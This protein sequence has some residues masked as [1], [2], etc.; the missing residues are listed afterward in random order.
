MQPFKNRRRLGLLCVLLLSQ[1]L[2]ACV[3]LPV[4]Y[5]RHRSVV[6]EPYAGY[7]QPGAPRDDRG[8]RDRRD[9]DSY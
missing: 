1:G 4:P 6:A 5:H 8:R 2:S 3:I 7:G 9:R